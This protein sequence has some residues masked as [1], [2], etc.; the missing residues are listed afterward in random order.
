[1]TKIVK[2]CVSC[3]A[4]HTNVELKDFTNPVDSKTKY[5][6]CPITN[7]PVLFTDAEAAALPDMPSKE[8]LSSKEWKEAVKVIVNS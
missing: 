8:G 1:M 2:N 6:M 4:H 7:D 5:F 3:T